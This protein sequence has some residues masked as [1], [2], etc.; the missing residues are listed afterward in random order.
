MKDQLKIKWLGHSCFKLE[1][2]GSSLVIDPYDHVDGYPE[3][4][5]RAELVL[6]SHEHGDHGYRQAIEIISHEG[7]L[8]FKVER[9]DTFHDD[10]GGA[11]RGN[12]LVHI[13]KA[14]DHTVVHLG[15]LGH[16]LSEAQAE[17]LAGCDLLLVPVG[18]YYTIDAAMAKRVCDAVKPRVI[19]PMHYCGGG[20]GYPVLADVDGFTGLYTDKM[21][22]NVGDD[23]FILTDDTPE[24]IAVLSFK[25]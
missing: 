1:Y 25:G 9:M 4:H 19:I 6:C 18:G 7:Q 8:P 20:Y 12:N 2:D 10:C 15:D 11:K 23:T 21:I 14:G 13:I 22:N 17:R 16:M 5:E 3:L 24:Q